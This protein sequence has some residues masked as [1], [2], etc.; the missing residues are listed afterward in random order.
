MSPIITPNQTAVILADGSANRIGATIGTTT[1][2]ISIKSKKKPKTNI[3][4]ITII[5]LAQNPPGKEFKKSLTKSSPPN[6]LNAAVNMAAPSKM[7][8]TSE[9]VFAVSSITSCRVLFNFRTLVPLQI[10]EATSTKDARAPSQ[11]P[12][13]FAP[14]LITAL[15]FI[16]KLAK[17]KPISPKDAMANIAGK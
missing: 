3:T 2:A 10:K 6:A 9:V 14:V 16:L 17:Q 15:T 8:K 7:I 13:L 4:A 1:T 5:N 11:M 12:T